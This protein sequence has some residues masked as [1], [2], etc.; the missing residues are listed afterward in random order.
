MF[1]CGTL[2]R[3]RKSRLVAE[4][5]VK[6][7][8]LSEA[9]ACETGWGRLIEHGATTGAGNDASGV[10]AEN[11]LF[12]YPHSA[13]L[14]RILDSIH[15][16]VVVIDR[17]TRIVYANPAY[18]RILKIRV[19]RIIGKRMADI[20]PE[21]K[22]NRVVV[23]GVPVTE[24]EVLI[25]TLKKTVAVNIEPIVADDRVTGAVSVFRD[26]TDVMELTRKL[27]QALGLASKVAP[28]NA[29]VLIMGEN[30]VGKEVVARAIHLSSGRANKPLVRID[31]A[32]IPEILLESEL[33]GYEGA[34]SSVQGKEASL[35]RSRLRPAAPSFSTKWAR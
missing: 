35:G 8:P 2:A 20:E 22:I 28:T 18:T 17:D 10:T 11:G 23:D 24:E 33:F 25:K 32:S 4:C 7:K 21:A 19:D 13:G 26:I 3:G 27:R 30:G 34:G 31:C 16:G 1:P 5:P 12:G 14:M 6:G 15:E 9:G 29:T